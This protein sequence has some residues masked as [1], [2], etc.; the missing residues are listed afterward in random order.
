MIREWGGMS[1]WIVEYLSWHAA[2]GSE[3]NIVTHPKKYKSGTNTNENTNTI[4][5]EFKLFDFTKTSQK[6]E[7]ALT[8]VFVFLSFDGEEVGIH[9]WKLTISLR[10]S[11]FQSL[12]INASARGAGSFIQQQ[13]ATNKQAAHFHQMN[14]EQE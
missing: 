1:G 14:S 11:A 12:S 10:S 8:L 3:Q 13:Q 5:Q 6:Y 2:G 4:V 7:T 9:Y